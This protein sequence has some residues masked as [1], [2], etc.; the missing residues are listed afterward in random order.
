[1][2]YG[3]SLLTAL[4]ELEIADHL[5]NVSYPVLKDKR[6]FRS[7]ISHM[8]RNSVMLVRAVLEH[9]CRSKKIQL[10]PSDNSYA[11]DIFL[12]KYSILFEINDETKNTMKE[13]LFIDKLIKSEKSSDFQRED[14]Y[15]ILAGDYTVYGLEPKTIKK[16]IDLLKELNKRVKNKIMVEHGI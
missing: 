6:I 12:E 1:M 8:V 9:Q 4:R 5:F 3:K 10:V 15:Y 13:L 7:T 11:L 14:R 16:Y 2:E